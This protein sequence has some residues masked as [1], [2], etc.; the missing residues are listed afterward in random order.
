MAGSVTRS[1]GAY[2]GRR[3]N[4]AS[5]ALA[6]LLHVGLLLGFGVVS[7]LLDPFGLL[8]GLLLRLVEVDHVAGDLLRAELLHLLRPQH[9]G[10]AW[11]A[12]RGR[13]LQGGRGGNAASADGRLGIAVGLG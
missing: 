1:G 9:A 2:R 12:G 10:L 3:D 6:R 11:T 8:L 7:Q 5:L 13:L 4:I